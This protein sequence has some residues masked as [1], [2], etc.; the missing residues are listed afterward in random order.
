MDPR[1]RLIK[2]ARPHFAVHKPASRQTSVA[3]DLPFHPQHHSGI[4]HSSS[5]NHIN[6]IHHSKTNRKPQSKWHQRQHKRYIFTFRID[7]RLQTRPETDI[8]HPDPNHCRQGTSWQGSGREEGG[9]QE[10]RSSRRREEEAHKDA[11]G[12]LQLVHLQG[13]VSTIAI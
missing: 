2:N 1:L 3:N 8:V 9:R 13:Y 5:P 6:L 11:Q 4:H 7:L 10:D 12:D